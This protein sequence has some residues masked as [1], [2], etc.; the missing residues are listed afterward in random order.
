MFAKLCPYKKSRFSFQS[1]SQQSQKHNSAISGNGIVED[2]FVWNRL[3]FFFN[4]GVMR[5]TLSYDFV[6]RQASFLATLLENL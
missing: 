2:K 4:N 6:G 3:G 1:L 5:F